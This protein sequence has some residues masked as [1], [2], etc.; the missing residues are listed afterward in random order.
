MIAMIKYVMNYINGVINTYMMIR[1][2][3][4]LFFE[5]LMTRV[6]PFTVIESS[7]PL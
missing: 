7:K 6:S 3:T 2:A 5:N 4:F 1:A